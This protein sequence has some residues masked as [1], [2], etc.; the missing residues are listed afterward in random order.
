MK[1][2]QE[3]LQRALNSV[4]RS[5]N[6]AYTKDL[7]EQARNFVWP[8]VPFASQAIVSATAF[9]A[10]L[11][12]TQLSG[13][14]L[15]VSCATPGLSSCMGAVGVGL[16]SCMASLA[17]QHC[18][19]SFE[20]AKRRRSIQLN[21]EDLCRD[22]LVGMVAFRLMGGVYR[23]LLP[24]DV[25]TVGACARES[26]PVPLRSSFDPSNPQYAGPVQK[27]EL[28]RMYRRDGCHHCGKRRGSKVI[29]DHQ[30]PTKVTAAMVVPTLLE[31]A[32]RVVAHN[33][34]AKLASEI[35][36]GPNVVRRLSTGNGSG[37]VVQRFYPQCQACCTKQA[38]AVRMDRQALVLHRGAS[39]WWFVGA[40][41]GLQHVYNMH[42]A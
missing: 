34:F 29:G 1:N 14:A 5:I 32:E 28:M 2:V 31:V 36:G 12:L 35:L 16:A 30:P 21:L 19:N 17:S 23:N 27:A 15:R 24:S 39:D 22:M 33:G 8:I 25:R 26:I 6:S 42:R 38:L 40:L 4:E 9:S 10:G 7:F 13:Y 18:R 3:S 41:V 37:K 11:G 20:P